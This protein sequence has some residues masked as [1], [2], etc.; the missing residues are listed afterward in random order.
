VSRSETD[1]PVRYD[2]H[3][4]KTAAHKRR[5]L[6]I[7][8]NTA[9]ALVVAI[10]V[11]EALIGS[12]VYGVDTQTTSATNDDISLEVRYAT[13]TR[14][15][16][17]VPLEV[18]ISRQ[19]GFA[20]PIVLTLTADYLDVFNTQGPDPTP[21]SETATANDLILTFDPPPGNTF[22]VRWNLTAKPVGS[23]TT[24]T[25]HIAV[26]DSRQQTIVDVNFD[27]KVRP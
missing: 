3:N 12:S 4:G 23:F 17:A 11:I 7:T 26:I 16:L 15:Q 9:V 2:H 6:Y 14:G 13:V 1:S 8:F 5:A 18:T 20:E 27:T 24:A 19:G 22:V 21:S 25:A 10:A